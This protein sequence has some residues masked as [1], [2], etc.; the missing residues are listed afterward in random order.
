MN[1]KKPNKNTKSKAPLVDTIGGRGEKLTYDIINSGASLYLGVK[2]E[3]KEERSVP[4]RKDNSVTFRKVEN[5]L[6]LEGADQSG[7]RLGVSP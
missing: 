3:N 2:V 4:C 1:P 7:G 5:L 6:H